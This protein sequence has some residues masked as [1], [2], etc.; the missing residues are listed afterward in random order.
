ME[1]PALT[2]DMVPYPEQKVVVEKKGHSTT[3]LVLT[4]V[5]VSV[6]VALICVVAFLLYEM[7]DLKKTRAVAVPVAPSAQYVQPPV[8]YV[9]ES[10]RSYHR[11]VI[12]DRD[13]DINMSSPILG[14]VSVVRNRHKTK[15]YPVVPPKTVQETAIPQQVTPY[16]QTYDTPPGVDLPD[17]PQDIP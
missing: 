14:D 7:N 17:R 3:T 11:P 16:H 1:S 10:Y 15:D 5:S 2:K 13:R 9:P 4:S 6:I 8:Q 12:H